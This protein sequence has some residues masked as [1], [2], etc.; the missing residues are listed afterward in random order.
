MSLP[1]ILLQEQEIILNHKEPQKLI[2]LV[3]IQSQVDTLVFDMSV[4]K[5]REDCRSLNAK[6]IKCIKPAVEISKKLAEE[7]KKVVAQ[8]VAFR[9]TFESG[10]REIADKIKQPLVEYENAIEQ[11]NALKQEQ[12]RL[13]QERI[14][15]ESDWELAIYM[16]KDWDAQTAQRESERKLEEERLKNEALEKELAAKKHQEMLIEKAKQEAKAA[17]ERESQLA[18]E[19][20]E[21]EKQARER[22]LKYREKLHSEIQLA[23][24]ENGFS[25]DL[26]A[27]LINLV[28]AKLIPH[29]FIKY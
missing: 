3:R 19:R 12:E 10:V 9:K 1:V 11:E 15:L 23:L 28:D 17:A 25:I 24:C 29:L 6:V 26:A 5:D 13:K 18:L 20:L 22:D 14:K 7:A 2:E 27:S 4:K 8:D 16:N 21:R